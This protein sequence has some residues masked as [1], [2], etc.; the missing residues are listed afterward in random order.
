MFDMFY[1]SNN[2][3][4]FIENI[5]FRPVLLRVS[6]VLAHPIHSTLFLSGNVTLSA[7]GTTA[8]IAI[9]QY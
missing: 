6:Y 1:H 8:N 9:Q 5:L 3:A 7:G 4:S 2:T